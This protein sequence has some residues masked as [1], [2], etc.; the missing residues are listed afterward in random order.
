MDVSD[1]FFVNK[2]PRLSSWFRSPNGL[3]GSEEHPQKALSTS[4]SHM[5]AH[6]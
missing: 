2:I 5:E 6:W 4:L 1:R 3:V